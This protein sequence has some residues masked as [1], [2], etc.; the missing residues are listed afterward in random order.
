MKKRI[1]LICGMFMAALLLC[2]CGGPCEVHTFGE[3]EILEAATCTAEGKQI[4]RCT[5]CDAQEEAAIPVEDHIL[6]DWVL[7]HEP[8]CTEEG[9]QIRS[10]QNCTYSVQDKIAAIGHNFRDWTTITAP[11]CE[12]TG[13]NSRTCKECGLEE[14]KTVA[15]L[16]HNYEAFVCTTCQ[17]AQYAFCEKGAFF[18][19]P[20]G[21]QVKI[22]SFQ[23][24]EYEGYN[25]YR[26][27]YTLRNEVPDTST[28]EGMFRLHF[29]DGSHEPQ[30]GF[31]NN[32]FYKESRNF[33]YEWKLLKTQEPVLLEYVP[34]D[35]GTSQGIQENSLLWNIS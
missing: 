20:D 23:K 15:A 13:K 30:Y 6:G 25:L 4:R 12:D 33:I 32:L 26:L 2:A 3:W 19:G 5:D 27:T 24:T 7:D 16:G 14:T 31:F 34:F 18:E 1:V 9:L 21:L 29:S 22:I 11:T 28:C 8:N 17:E 35:I 10:C